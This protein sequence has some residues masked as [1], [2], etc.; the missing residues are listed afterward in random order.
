MLL[1]LL[2][3]HI[4]SALM[5]RKPGRHSLRIERELEPGIDFPQKEHPLRLGE[6]L[7]P[8]LPRRLG[9]QPVA[10]PGDREH[11]TWRKLESTDVPVE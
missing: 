1:Q 6:D 7:D 2:S 10:V 5:E 8:G 11:E 4:L 9:P 3:R